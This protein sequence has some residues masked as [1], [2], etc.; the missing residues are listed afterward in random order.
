M[1]FMAGTVVG[2]IH[3]GIHYAVLQVGNHDKLEPI[4]KSIS[5]RPEAMAF[6]RFFT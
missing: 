5:E 6:L 3:S 2:F 4:F 1:R